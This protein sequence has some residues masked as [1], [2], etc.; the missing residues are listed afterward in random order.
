MQPSPTNQVITTDPKLPVE[1]ATENCAKKLR[2]AFLRDFILVFNLL[3]LGVD[4]DGSPCSP[5]PDSNLLHDKESPP[6]AIPPATSAARDP[7]TSLLNTATALIFVASGAG[8][9]AI[10]K[11]IWEDEEENQ[12]PPPWSSSAQGDLAGFW[13]R[14]YPNS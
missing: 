10:L 5:F 13:K 2:L 4:P 12:S 11:H 8:K 6:S 14:Q 3:I 1:A 9:T 7:H